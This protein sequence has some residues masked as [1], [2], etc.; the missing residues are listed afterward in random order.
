[1]DKFRRLC[2][3]DKVLFQQAE[4]KIKGKRVA[5]AYQRHPNGAI[6]PFSLAK[7]MT[8]YVLD[9]EDERQVDKLYRA[10]LAFRDRICVVLGKDPDEKWD[11]FCGRHN[12]NAKIPNVVRQYEMAEGAVGTR[13][14]RTG[15]GKVYATPDP[16]EFPSVRRSLCP[17]PPPNRLGSAAI[18]PTPPKG[19]TP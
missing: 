3:S 11:A 9:L 7:A 13:T 4:D 10:K 12:T 14:L 18:D 8:D 6:D 5:E 19:P 17:D 15:A 16:V 1:M 2:H